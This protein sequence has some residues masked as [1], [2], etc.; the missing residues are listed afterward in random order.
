MRFRRAGHGVLVSIVVVSLGVQALVAGFAVA[1]PSGPPPTPVPP[2][3]SPSP[4]PQALKTPAD[5]TEVPRVDLPAAL[6]ANLDDGQEMFAKDASARRPIASLTKIMTALLVLERRSLDDVV[7]IS[8]GAVFE[9]GDYGATSALGLRAGERRSVRELLDA[10]MLQSAN[11]AAVA[12]AIE[13]SGSEDRFVRLMNQRAERLGMGSTSFFSANGLDDRGRS[14][15]R[16]LLRLVRAAY[17]TPGFADIVANKFRRIPG[18]A[19]GKDR[20][21]QNRNAMLWLY[22]GSTGVK[23]GFTAGAGYCLITVAER[24]GRRLVAIALGSRDEVFSE[25]ATLLNYGFEGFADETFVRAGDSLGTVGIRG[26]AV[27]TLAGS[28]LEALVPPG[29]A[30]QAH[31]RLVVWPGAVFPP[32]PGERIGTLRVALPG[33][34]VGSVPVL[35]DEVP[36]PPPAGDVPWWIR[37]A[38]VVIE[39]IAGAVGGSFG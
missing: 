9:E 38:G 20:R 21:I 23:T 1:D 27:P 34:V 13:L 6:L 12:L 19:G 14:T 37:S 28:T 36:P 7:T 15:P 11:D 39:A 5:S 17:S 29:S 32:A 18:A 2:N 25:A 30:G 26:G 22:P 4:F 24:D 10:L 35:V 3:G 16:D 31:E 8:G 33:M